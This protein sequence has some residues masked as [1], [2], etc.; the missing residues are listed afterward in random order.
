MPDLEWS[1]THDGHEAAG[2]PSLPAAKRRAGRDERERI[3]LA[4][5]RGHIVLSLITGPAFA[6]LITSGR[7]IE[8][9]ATAMVLLHLTLRSLDDAVNIGWSY[10]WNWDHATE[11]PEQVSWPGRLVLVVTEWLR[12]R[13]LSGTG[14]SESPSIIVLP[15]ELLA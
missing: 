15:P 10:A 9:F 1:V 8:E 3:R 14:N 4:R 6:V 7:S 12:A 2:Y 13:Q 5:I 11:G